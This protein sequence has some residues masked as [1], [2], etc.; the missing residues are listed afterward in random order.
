[1]ST[2]IQVKICGVRTREAARG[3]EAAGADFVGFNFVPSSKRRIDAET[4]LGIS[5]EVGEIACVG[6]FMDQPI[7]EIERTADAVGLEWIQLH[8]KEPPE[9]VKTLAGRFKVIKAISVD[10]SF[11]KEKVEGYAA[12]VAAFLFDGPKPG[13]GTRFSWEALKTPVTERPYF[14]AGGLDPDNVGDAVRA[15]RPWGV[16]TASGVEVFGQQDI[17]RIDGFVRRARSAVR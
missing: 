15:L 7:E 13:S 5:R 12:D 14:I 2:R 6:V 8:G 17:R 1:L 11:S 3:A 4:A 10:A 16:D 9:L